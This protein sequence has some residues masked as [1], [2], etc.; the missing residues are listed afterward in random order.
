MGY[1]ERTAERVRKILAHRTDVNE[2]RMMGG[3]VFMVDGSM[4]CGISDRGLMVRV[5]ADAH[6]ATL[7]ERYVHPMEIGGGRKPRG[8]VRVDAAGFAT[9]A[10]LRA[11]IARGLAF[12]A[13]L[14][15]KAAKPA[16]KRAR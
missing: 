13:T 12:V 7:T 9:D 1:D 5:G 10:A 15:P 2:R 11:W 3:L 4:C 14:P 16:R 8:F 6:A